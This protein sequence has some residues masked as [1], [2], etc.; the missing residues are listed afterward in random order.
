MAIIRVNNNSY[1]NGEFYLDR[2]QQETTKNFAV[3]LALLSSYWKST[4]DGPNYA[5]SLKA[6]AIAL[7]QIRI[8]LSDI[9]DDIQYSN[10]RGEFVNQV[11]ASLAFPDGNPELNKTDIDFRD[12]LVEILKLYFKGSIPDSIQK[13]ISLITGTDVNLIINYEEARKPGSGYDISDEFG[14][15]VDIVLTSPAAIDLFNSDKNIR[16]FLQILRP[17]HTLYKIRYIIQDTYLGNQSLPY[18]GPRPPAK[19]IDSLSMDLSDYRYV[20][21]RKFV[22]GVYKVDPDGSK[23]PYTAS[24]EDHSGDF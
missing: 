3:L 22:L 23:K 12:F 11:I 6:T 5:R 21:H 16:M 2:L 8:S 14:F 4:V 15:T 18:V 7:A 24:L 17:A 13:G 20:D 9:Y 10:T 1:E 19:I